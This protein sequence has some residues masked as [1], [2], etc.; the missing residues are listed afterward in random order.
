MGVDAAV[1]AVV[2]ILLTRL[3][4]TLPWWAQVV[5]SPLLVAAALWAARLPLSWGRYRH[6]RSWGFST[7]TPRGW[8][9]DRL[10][11]LAVGAVLTVLG[12]GG[13]LALAHLFPSGWPW[14]A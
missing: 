11:S 6:E 14:A 4:P 7:Q 13:L 2:L 5:V 9:A 3:R 8:A 1:A 10:R 12:V